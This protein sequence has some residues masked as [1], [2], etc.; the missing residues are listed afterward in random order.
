MSGAV[1]AHASYNGSGTQGLAVTNKINSPD[2]DVMSVFW[3]KN[4]TTR[5]LLYGS[6]TIE[7]ASSGTGGSASFGGSQVFTVNNDIDCL[8]DMYVALSVNVDT[9]S[10]RYLDPYFL[11]KIINRVEFQVGT[12]VWQTLENKD[13]LAINKT[14][15]GEGQYEKMAAQANGFLKEGGIPVPY[16]KQNTPGKIEESG[17][18]TCYIHLPIL[19]K[20]LGPELQKFSDHVE[21]GYLMAAAP[22]QT[23]K[24]KLYYAHESELTSKWK[25][26]TEAGLR[27]QPEKLAQAMDL[28]NLL[29]NEINYYMTGQSPLGSANGDNS[30]LIEAAVSRLN[31]QKD[32]VDAIIASNGRPSIPP[33]ATFSDLD[34][35]L[36]AQHMIMCNEEREQMKAQPQGIPKRIKMT[37]NVQQDLKNGTSTINLDH[38]SLYAS[39][40]IITTSIDIENVEL[41][42]NSS[43]FSGVIPSGML[44]SPS[45]SAL[46]LYNNNFC[47]GPKNYDSYDVKTYVF[48]LASRAYG[49]S[50]VPLN[51]FDNIR[52][53]VSPCNLIETSALGGPIGV[54]DVTCVGETTALYKAGAASLAMY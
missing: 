47:I 14:E 37:Q 43:S 24:I 49:G 52:L 13:I 39:H 25:A 28:K 19:T 44:T 33:L 29:V 45:T 30:D 51:R 11:A 34:V 12:Q 42:L 4:D 41:L 53:K 31:T 36:Y 6:S 15:L 18:Y 35:K 46:G 27:D 54:I 10:G 20:T 7:I 32:E 9:S 26:R 50:S 17:T 2:G 8:G 16:S 48:P 38:F 23:V 22:H 40:L 5:Q 21:D 1:A 3:N